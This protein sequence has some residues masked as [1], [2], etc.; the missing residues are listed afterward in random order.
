[1]AKTVIAAEVKV[2]GLDKAGQSV[3]SFK[4]QLREAQNEVLTLSDKFGAASTQAT[5]A[6]K[7]V[8]Q[9]KDAI[10]DAKALTETFNPDKKFVALGGA[11]Q[12]ITAGFS[13]YQG[14]LGL[15][16]EN[17]K[18]VEQVLLK[19]QAAMALQQGISGIAGALDSFKLLKSELIGGVTKAFGTL[20]A[21]IISTGIGALA[22]ALGYVVANFDSV[23]KAV[24]NLI[25]GLGKVVDFVGDLITSFTDLI[26]VTSDA[27]RAQQKFIETTEK[28]I[29]RVQ[30]FLD[31]NADRYDEFTIRKVKARLEYNK[32][33]VELDKDETRSEAEKSEL[34]KQYALKTNREIDR[35]ESDRVSKQQEYLKTLSEK[36]QAEAEKRLA[37]NKAAYE[38]EQAAYEKYQKEVEDFRKNIAAGKR[39]QDAADA[40]YDKKLRA[41]QDARDQAEIDRLKTNAETELSNKA[42]LANLNVLNN[43]NDVNAKIEK[44][45]AD[46]AVELSTLAEGDLQKQILAKQAEDAITKI[47]KDAADEQLEIKKKQRENEI[48]LAENTSGILSKFADLAGK[49]TAAGKVLAIASA[50]IDTY[51]AASKALNANYG[52]FGPAAQVARFASVA[53]TIGLGIKNIKAIASV[54]TPGGGGGGT[55]NISAT[56]PL[57]PQAQTTTLDQNSINQIGNASNRAFVLETDVTNNQERIRRLNRAAR[58]N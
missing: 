9:L 2:E 42:K 23:K 21:A 14:L 20:R 52:I 34:L 47:K 31:T 22:V 18:E 51:A 25:P 37:K 56:A 3:G 50:T 19:V 4:K 8:A 58:I 48:Q 38:K 41:E 39:A 36:E 44:I 27:E 26:G 12:G 17:G 15:V 11:I 46:L 43:P 6:A 5:N 33:I 55:P 32:K 1:M 7:R 13:T 16:G 57:A 35:A 10:G 54:K 49:Q 30:D 29:T 28:G 53:A 40:D 45:K 24:L